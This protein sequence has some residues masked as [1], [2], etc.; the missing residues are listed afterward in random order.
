MID[1]GGVEVEVREIRYDAHSPDAPA[2]NGAAQRCTPRPVSPPL[3]T[4]PLETEPV[5][6][7]NLV[8]KGR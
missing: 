5:E 6:D 8:T 1:A 7:F 4:G 2:S 3:P